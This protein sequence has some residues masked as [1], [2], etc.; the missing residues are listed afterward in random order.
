MTKA[1]LALAT[2]L[3][4]L[5]AFGCS[6]PP[7]PMGTTGAVPED[8]GAVFARFDLN[9]DGELAQAEFVA[10]RRAMLGAAGAS[11]PDAVLIEA[12]ATQDADRNGR[13]TRAEFTATC[14]A[15]PAPGATP[16]A[17]TPTPP[18]ATP[19]PGSAA[20]AGPADEIPAT[21]TPPPAVVRKPGKS[22]TTA[23]CL[24][25][26]IIINQNGEAGLDLTEWL[27]YG[28]SVG[29]TDTEELKRDF[30]SRDFDGN[31]ILADVEYCAYPILGGSPAPVAT[32][33]PSGPVECM[34]HF[35]LADVDG[36]GLLTWEEYLNYQ[37]Q[38]LGR[39]ASLKA[40][41]FGEFDAF[42]TNRDERL[43]PREFCVNEPPP[44]APTPVPT[45]PPGCRF[46]FAAVDTDGDGKVTWDEYR[47]SLDIGYTGR[48]DEFTQF[49][50][51]SR[52]NFER[53]DGDTDGWLIR[54]EACPE[55]DG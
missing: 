9:L 41:L 1:P 36:D 49:I 18:G 45:P 3:S 34:G 13:V 29:L 40:E 14:A 54:A 38:G 44:P 20:T 39:P 2:C 12:F 26:Y 32:P 27:N 37:V 6:L 52:V 46:D 15:T 7:M 51:N 11:L 42:D 19:T 55:A 24:A 47:A 4:L 30:L 17:A 5:A 25:S 23:A 8:C 16:A 28:L 22:T 50:N 21:P 33:T 53:W 35:S 10:G 31:G 48:K 43:Q